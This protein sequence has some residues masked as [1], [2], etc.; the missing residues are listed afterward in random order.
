[1][2]GAIRGV[3]RKKKPTSII[4]EANGVG[5][6]LTISLTTFY[7]LPEPGQQVELLV[8]TAVRDDAIALFGFGEEIEKEL[9]EELIKTPKVGP[10]SALALL[11]AL[12]GAR[13]I[14][15]I[16][17]GDKNAI[18]SAPGIGAKTAERLIIELTD[19]LNRFDEIETS[20]AGSTSDAIEKLDESTRADL[21]E[22][23]IALGYKKAEAARALKRTERGLD[24]TATQTPAIA[25]LLKMT[26]NELSSARL[27]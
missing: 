8:H 26:L 11:S 24:P 4:V 12:S 6:L 10:K 15:A 25:E 17:E 1:M 21:I 5:Y 27:K 9:F 13:L 7:K 22:A 2:I 19:R 23:L 3:L 20:E 16:R 18:A 14:R